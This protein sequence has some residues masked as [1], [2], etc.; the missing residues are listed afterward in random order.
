MMKNTGTGEHYNY[1]IWISNWF[2][3]NVMLNQ[4]SCMFAR[5]QNSFT[6]FQ[7]IIISIEGG[8]TKTTILTTDFL[9]VKY[10]ANIL[11]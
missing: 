2:Q 9:Q 10:S 7:K 5:W 4:I 3:V 11:R 8:K 6:E 1:K